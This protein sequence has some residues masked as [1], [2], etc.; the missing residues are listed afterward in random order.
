MSTAQMDL[1]S[2][3]ISR[4]AYEL[5]EARGCPPGDGSEDW[6]AALAELTADHQSQNGSADSGGPASAKRSPAATC[7]S[8]ASSH[9]CPLRRLL[10]GRRL[11]SCRGPQRAV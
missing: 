5:W 2:D 1:S 10:T 11:A 7:S 8:A 3:A 4:R 9:R 6:E